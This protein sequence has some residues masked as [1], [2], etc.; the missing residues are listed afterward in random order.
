MNCYFSVCCC[1][2]A[3]W[4]AQ[5]TLQWLLDCLNLLCRVYLGGLGMSNYLFMNFLQMHMI[6]TLMFDNWLRV[7]K[8]LCLL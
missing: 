5:G 3:S 4:T 8:L 6:C 7:Y 2:L 1:E